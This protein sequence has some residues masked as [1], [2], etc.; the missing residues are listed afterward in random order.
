MQKKIMTSKITA[1][2]VSMPYNFAIACTGLVEI[3]FTKY[4]SSGNILARMH[5]YVDGSDSSV[6]VLEQSDATLGYQ[7][8]TGL[9][10]VG[11][12]FIEGETKLLTALPVTGDITT[13]QFI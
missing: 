10:I 3:D 13:F 1:T 11:C 5:G 7:S 8:T 4:S 6:I 2:S 12:Y 9:F